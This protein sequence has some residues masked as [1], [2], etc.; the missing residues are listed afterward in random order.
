MSS[1][2]SEVINGLEDA[3]FGSVSNKTSDI[4]TTIDPFEDIN[5]FA[6]DAFFYPRVIHDSEP[7]KWI[8]QHKISH[9]NIRLWDLLFFIPNAAFLSFVMFGYGKST[10]RLKGMT[11]NSNGLIVLYYLLLIMTASC[12]TRSLINMVL[13]MEA[14][15]STS[16]KVGWV[17]TKFV[18]LAAEICILII[19]SCF[20]WIGKN[21]LYISL[22]IGTVI[23]LVVCSIQLNL[24]INVPY[25]GYKVIHTGVDLYGHGGP[26]YHCVLSGIFTLIYLLVMILPC[27]P[28]NKIKIQVTAAYYCYCIPQ[29][30]L[31][32]ITFIGALLV[33]ENKHR[34]LCMTDFT[35]F[36]YF[37]FTP[38][39]VYLCYIRQK[40]TFKTPNFLFAYTAQVDE[41]QDEG[42]FIH[43]DSLNSFDQASGTTIIKQHGSHLA[44]TTLSPG[45]QSPELI[46][47]RDLLIP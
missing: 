17:F 46:E 38:A 5:P 24:E 13:T 21:G 29:F 34:G 32:L 44:S 11:G 14:E 6:D 26:V 30:V 40:V 9:I 37:S 20:G 36:I 19:T 1:I 16:E 8:I 27:L 12:V 35:S 2:G 33:A 4:S 18:Y 3:L 42:M 25:Y 31:N 28:R 43:S 15:S 10:Q 7:C 41:N 22:I 23:S 39:L 47:D 45:L